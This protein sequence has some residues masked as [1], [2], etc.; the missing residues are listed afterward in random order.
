MVVII[1]LMYVRFWISVFLCKAKVDHVYHI[2]ELVGSHQEVL[3][4]DIAMDEGLGVEI[5][6]ARDQLIG[7]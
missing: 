3:W 4:L 2:S 6:D 5:I 1:R 7:Q